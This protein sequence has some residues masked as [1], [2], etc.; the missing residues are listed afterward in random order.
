MVTQHVHVHDDKIP[1]ENVSYS[2]NMVARCVTCN[3]ES[4]CYTAS[5]YTPARNVGCGSRQFPRNMQILN[6]ANFFIL[7]RN[8]VV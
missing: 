7:I 1:L 6:T 5:R 2:S 8:Q 3:V 4:V